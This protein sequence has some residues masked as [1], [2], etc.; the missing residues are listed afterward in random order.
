MRAI[1]RVGSASPAGEY[2]ASVLVCEDD[3]AWPPR[4]SASIRDG[5]A[6]SRSGRLG[7]DPLLAPHQ[8]GRRTRL[9]HHRRIQPGA[10]LAPA[11]VGG[12]LSAEPGWRAQ[13]A[14]HRGSCPPR[15]SAFR[16]PWLRLQLFGAA[17][18]FPSG[19]TCA[20]TL[21]TGEACS[22]I[23]RQMEALV[24]RRRLCCS[25]PARRHP[26]SRLGPMGQMR[27]LECHRPETS[28]TP[29]A[30]HAS[31][32]PWRTLGASRRPPQSQL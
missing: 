27:G 28:L 14:G 30:R 22:R 4:S 19:P 15:R 31:R 1:L 13:I 11:G 29:N 8:A 16:R 10:L 7:S 5:V 12:C 2:G 9:R 25:P 3:S 6:C 32:V 24:H 18:H 20:P 26:Q 21:T 17:R 23:N